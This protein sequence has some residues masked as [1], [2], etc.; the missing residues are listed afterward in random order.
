MPTRHPAEVPDE[1]EV[2]G[3]SLVVWAC[4]LSL[5]FLVQG[6]I[7]LLSY[8]YYGFD[9]DPN[10][11]ALGF[12]LDPI[13]A[14][15]HLLWGVVGSI[16]GFFLPRYSTYFLLAFA[17]FYTVM[18]ILGTFTS[19]HF[20]MHLDARVNLFHWSLLPFAWGIGLY[21]LWQERRPA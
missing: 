17:A 5:Y 15:V 3:V 2:N 6:A 12:R 21:G 7:I 8:A 1:V 16:I 18:A 20:G 9:T 11:F 4:R 13:H 19:Y 10:S 14:T